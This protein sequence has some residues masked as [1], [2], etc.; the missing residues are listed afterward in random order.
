MGARRRHHFA[1]GCHAEWGLAVI[2]STLPNG[3]FGTFFISTRTGE[4]RR[5]LSDNESGG[6]LTPDGTQLIYFFGSPK[7]DFGI[8]NLRDGSKRQLTTGKDSC[9]FYWLSYGAKQLIVTRSAN[10]QAIV[11]VDMRAA[12]EKKSSP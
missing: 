3:G 8:F 12:L 7:Q 11:T 10:T 1:T 9:S 2:T 4:G 5:V 6:D